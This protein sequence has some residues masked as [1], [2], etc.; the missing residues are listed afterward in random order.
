MP[1][2]LAGPWAGRVRPTSAPG[3]HHG[4]VLDDAGPVLAVAFVAAVRAEG[5]EPDPALRL[6]QTAAAET[7]GP[8]AAQLAGPGALGPR[9]EQLV[10]AEDRTRR[11]AWYTPAWLAEAIVERAIPDVRAARRGPVL[12]PACGGGAFL[13]AAA[14]R[15]V[16]LGCTPA[17]ALASLRGV[18]VDPTAVAV[19]EAA[20]WWWGARRG[21]PA[22]VA[23]QL[24]VGD[25]LLDDTT[26]EPRGTVVGN[27]PFLGQLRSA[28][29]VAADRRADLRAR[30]GD[31]V[32]AYTDPAWLFVLHAVEQ[33][34]PGGRVALVQPQSFLAARDAA[35]IRQ[36]L[37]GCVELV[38]AIVDDGTAFDAGVSVCAPVLQR[39]DPSRPPGRPNDWVA[40][41]ADA[42][43]VPRVHLPGTATLGDVASVHAGFRDEFYGLVDG[44]SE[45]ASD[46]TSPD[47]PRLVTAGAIDPFAVLGRPQRFAGRRW[48]RPVVDPTRLT[49]RAARWAEVQAGP[50]VLVATQ[51][52]VLEAVAD[53]EGALLGSVPV[54][55]VRP[56]DPDDVWHLLAALL[57]PAASAWLLRR[58]AGTALSADAC[59]PTP[60]LLGE[61]PLPGNRRRWDEAAAVAR[62]LS[63]R[64][65]DPSAFAAPADAA[66]AIDDP[67]LRRW[68]QERRPRR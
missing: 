49:G 4:R 22:V 20:L 39:R 61:L 33:V 58:S 17:Q 45:E 56:A 34:V 50:K 11:G 47:C 21:A 26:P 23:D 13:L 16:T 24:Q 8:A 38:D 7:P 42:A 2:G 1:P 12:D 43:G 44:V 65:G 36:E 15:L 5:L 3:R 37:D 64:G 62:C 54:L 46:G 55:C 52:R 68:W 57:A 31:A 63:E 30:Y 14:D 10:T 25:A 60:A 41:L 51:T 28:T 6:L 59:R 32:R 9:H 40:P 18:D 35:A 48:I 53:P 27:P 67:A 29:T 66:Y 19:T